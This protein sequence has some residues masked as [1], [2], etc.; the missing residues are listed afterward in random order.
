LIRLGFHASKADTSLFFYNKG[1]ITIYILVYVDDIIV[2]SSSDKATIALLQD[3][4]ED[5][6]LKDLGELHYFLGIKVKR[7]NNG[8]V[9]TQEKYA[10]DLLKRVGMSDCKSVSTPLSTS[11][12][13]SLYE[14]ILLDPEDATR[15]RSIVRALQYLTLTRPD[16]AFSVNKVCQF[17]H[18]PTTAHWAAVK[19]ILR[20]IKQ[21]IRL[22]LKIHMSTSTLVTAYSDADWAGS[23]DD[24]R[25]TGGYAVF[26]RRNLVSWSARKQST[27]SR[28]ST[29]SEY[30]AV[31]DA[32]AE[33]MWIQIFLREIGVKSPLAAKM[34][35]DNIGA[36]YLSAN[37]VFHAR[38]KHIEVDYHFVRERVLRKLLEI[39]YVSTRD[40]VA[41][42]F[43]KALSVRLL[44]NFKYNLNLTRL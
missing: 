43:T 35:C 27:V 37:P 10:S 33:I 12:K 23:L 30:K 9:L 14:G 8:I 21:C 39:D 19:R 1:G 7:V 28:S 15:Y 17:L 22:G 38:T 40:Q 2:A 31:A 36:K 24:R 11:E 41:D 32:T 44:E 42:G 16:I 18:A 3:L 25:S 26:L 34:W 13:L 29:E 6:A 4:K 5:F 20:Y